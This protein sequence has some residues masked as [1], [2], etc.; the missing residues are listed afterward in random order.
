MK[1]AIDGSCGMARGI[2]CKSSEASP[3]L[4]DSRS[5]ARLNPQQ[6]RLPTFGPVYSKLLQ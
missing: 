4:D 6:W 2:N 5:P 3:Q 1:Q